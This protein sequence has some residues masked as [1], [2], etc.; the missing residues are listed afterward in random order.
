MCPDSASEGSLFYGHKFNLVLPKF[1]SFG[2][3]N[4]FIIIQH[5]Y[6]LLYLEN[7]CILITDIF[8]LSAVLG[9]ESWQF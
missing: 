9:S 3:F 2:K 8:Y 4:L 5:Y 6:L 7:Q 1:G